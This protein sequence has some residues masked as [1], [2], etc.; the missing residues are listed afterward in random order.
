MSG[1]A[2]PGR[3]APNLADVP[4]GALY[5]QIGGRDGRPRH[6][7]ITPSSRR[8]LTRM[9]AGAASAGLSSPG[10]ITRTY[11]VFV[12]DAARGPQQLFCRPGP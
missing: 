1:V 9:L 3:C 11:N 10:P 5:T 2:V 12:L 8:E 4:C 7:R 6:G